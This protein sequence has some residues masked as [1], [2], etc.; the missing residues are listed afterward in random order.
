MADAPKLLLVDDV[1]KLLRVSR[2]RVYELAR[3]GSLPAVHLGTRVR[4]P[5]DKIL[6][7]IDGGGDRL[8]ISHR[9]GDKT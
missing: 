8:I 7:W 6:R 2:R 9:N 3:D 5:E 1:A 4:F